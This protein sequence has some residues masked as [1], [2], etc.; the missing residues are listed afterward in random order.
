MRPERKLKAGSYLTLSSV[1]LLCFHY[2]ALW[3]LAATFAAGLVWWANVVLL[4]GPVVTVVA[5]VYTVR[6]PVQRIAMVA[7]V[8]AALVYAVIWARLISGLEWRG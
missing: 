1:A 8:V 7:N 4:A 6:T 3:V 5:L 2:Y